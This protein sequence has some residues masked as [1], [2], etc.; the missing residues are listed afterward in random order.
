MTS[1]AIASINMD[2]GTQPP[3]GTVYAIRRGYAEGPVKIGFTGDDVYARIRSL[4]T[5]SPEPLVP[6]G[7]AEGTQQD[8]RALHA[9]LDDFRMVG[10][11]FFPAK[12]VL[13]VARNLA[14]A[15]ASVRPGSGVF[16]EIP[17][18]ILTSDGFIRAADLTQIAMAR[19]VSDKR[20]AAKVER[21]GLDAIEQAYAHL[22][23]LWSAHPSLTMEQ[24]CRIFVQSDRHIAVAAE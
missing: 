20:R 5:G 14:D 3:S 23:R 10:E 6:M 1:V 2:G 12:K 21:G 17:D 19:L 24:A 16:A 15:V 4:Q 8:E 11:W 7:T 22:S 13:M 18:A 9:V